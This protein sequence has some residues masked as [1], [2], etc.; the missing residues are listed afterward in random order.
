MLD[1]TL[2]LTL[3]AVFA[4]V[5]LIAG[6]LTYVTLERSSPARRRLREFLQPAAKGAARDNVTQLYEAASPFLKK[7]STLI[8]KSP[9][10][11]SKLQRRLAVAGIHKQSH[12]VVYALSEIVGGVLGVLIPI[13]IFGW[14][15]ENCTRCSAVLSGTS[16]QASS[17][18]AE[19][20]GVKRRS[21]TAFPTRSTC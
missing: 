11:M 2:T 9:K 20:S 21:R 14:S 5:A 12:A 8:P 4:S 13:L 7:V 15:A 3:I 18:T 19:S 17:W 16:S 6:S 10:E 1:Q